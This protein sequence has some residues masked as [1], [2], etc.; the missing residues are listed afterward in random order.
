[1]ISN[2]S[3][4]FSALRTC[5]IWTLF[6]DNLQDNLS[7]LKR[8]AADRS[9]K[10]ERSKRLHA[11]MRESE[12]FEMWI[13]EQ[14]QTASSEEYG[15]DFE[16]LQVG[17]ENH[18]KNILLKWRFRL[19]CWWL[20]KNLLNLIFLFS[21]MSLCPYFCI[22][23]IFWRYNIVAFLSTLNKGIDVWRVKTKK[24]LKSGIHCLWTQISFLFFNVDSPQQI[25][26]V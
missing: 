5:Q 19:R 23:D 18:D 10:L 7:K 9:R 16:H 11:Y 22:I 13:E 1:M 17:V 6:Q 26:W 3:A 4:K 21:Q 25:W 12:D 15:Q 14:M 8:L 20:W 2:L 24:P